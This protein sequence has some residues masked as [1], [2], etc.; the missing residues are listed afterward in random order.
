MIMSMK[1]DTRIAKMIYFES[2]GVVACSGT[3]YFATSIKV[4]FSASHTTIKLE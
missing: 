1:F 3:I 2:E 4:Q